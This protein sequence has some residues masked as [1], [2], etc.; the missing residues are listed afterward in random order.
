M[1]Y[2]TRPIITDINGNPISQYYN[3]VTDEYEPVEGSGGGNK[4]VLYNVDGTENNELSL[5]PILDKLSQLTGTVIDEEIREGNEIV[6]VGNED[7]RIDNEINRISTFNAQ[8]TRVE[9]IEEQVPAEIV[10]NLEEIKT[11]VGPLTSLLTTIKTSIVNAI[12]SLK[13]DLDTHKAEITTQ[14]ITISRD[15]TIEGA[16]VVATLPNRKIQAIKIFGL[17]NG[18]KRVC[19]GTWMNGTQKGMYY[20]NDS[21]P[22]DATLAITVPTPES[23]ANRT[24]GNVQSVSNNGFNIQWAKVGTGGVGTVTLNIEVYYHD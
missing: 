7:I 12:N 17:V 18:T 16:Q 15:V 13:S 14:L 3:E 4:V 21:Q 2:N 19:L 23:V 5:T 24:T 11:R 20:N 22:Y 8:I 6:R 1:A 9:Q 10:T